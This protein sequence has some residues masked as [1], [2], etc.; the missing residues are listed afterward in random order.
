MKKI[1]FE[2]I[3]KSRKLKKIKQHEL[4]KKVDVTP[5]YISML[6]NGKKEPSLKILKKI[7]QILDIELS[8]LFEE[9]KN[10][11]EELKPILNKYDIDDIMDKL[12]TIKSNISENKDL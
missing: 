3:K 9:E 8:S 11:V 1:Y 6:E 10:L 4:A 7:C 5:T 2:K 12:K